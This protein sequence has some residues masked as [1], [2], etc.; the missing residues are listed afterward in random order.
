MQILEKLFKIKQ[1]NTTI[2][3]EIYAGLTTFV[4]MSYVIFVNPAIISHGNEQIYNGVFFATCLSAGIGTLLMAFIAN[5]PFAQAPGMGLNAFFAFTTMP[6]LALLVGNANLNIITQYQM[7]LV[8]TFLSGVFFIFFTRYG[9]REQI[10]N[11]IPMNLKLSMSTGI[12]LFIS[13]LGLQSGGVVVDNQST[14]VELANFS[15]FANHTDALLTLL[16]FVLLSILMHK[17]ITGAVLITVLS[18]TVLSHIVGHSQL[19]SWTSF[20]ISSQ[21]SDFLD[22][23]FLKLDFSF[24]FSSKSVITTISTLFFAIIAVSVSDI[25]DSVGTFIATTEKADII[26]ENGN[27]PGFQRALL[28]DAIAT[29]AGACLGTSTV[30][31]YV[32]STAGVSAGGKTGMTSFT[33]GCLFLLAIFL[34]PFT[35][36]IPSCATAPALIYVGFWML[37]SIQKIDFD[38]IAEGI[39]AFITIVLMPLTYSISNGVGLGLISYVIIKTCAGS[40]EDITAPTWIMAALFL[41]KYVMLV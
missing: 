35:G 31:T 12:G 28:C 26:D 33:T 8:T 9:L 4:T 13:F 41:L 34:A 16:G 39:P 25:F 15:D 37:S 11:A 3:T 27:F 18:V 36:L 32:E 21:F 24:I 19:P 23:S 1:N 20:D 2:K 14:L 38:T 40:G 17:K 7:A 30:T 6:S 10:I 5:L 29:T 22:V